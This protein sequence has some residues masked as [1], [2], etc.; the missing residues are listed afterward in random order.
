MKMMN[1]LAAIPG[2]CMAVSMP[3]TG[4]AAAETADFVFKNGAVYTIDS[5]QPRA[6]AIAV[7]GKTI[8]YVGGNAGADA[9]VG[10]DTQ[11]I[12][13][14]GKMLLPGFIDAHA[15]PTHAYGTVGVDVQ[16][17]DAAAAVAAVK[18]WAD[19]HPDA[20]VIL[21]YGWRFNAFPLTGPTKELLDK[22][23][24]DR[25][26]VLLSID[27]HNT[28]LNSKA[29]AMAGID[30]STKD[31][32]PPTSYYQRDEKGEPTGY[33][34][35]VPAMQAALAKLNPPSTEVVS[36]A[37]R[38]HVARLA[39]V[40]VTGVYDAGMVPFS[41]QD[42]GY[43][44]Y[45]G[46]EKEDALPVRVVGSFYWNDPTVKDPVGEIQKLHKKFH[47]ELVQAGALK[48][49]VDGGDLA[50]TAVML[51]PYADRPGFHGDFVLEPK[52][53]A[54][55]V[56]KAQS[57]GIDTHAHVFGDGAMKAYLDA[58]EQAERAYPRSR[59]RHTAAHALYL[60]DDLIDRMARLNVT[61]AQS[62]VWHTPEPIN[63][64][65][66]EQTIGKQV[67]FTEYG[68]SGSILQKGGRLAL[69]SDWPSAGYVST[70]KPGTARLRRT[71]TYE[72]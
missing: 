48:I 46:L 1:R 16:Y 14:K 44:L 62:P 53:F 54:P 26:V 60:T 19:E 6:E 15:H 17:D 41:A 35:E 65:S 43:D 51:Q 69:G 39:Q 4:A 23:V 22:V 10:K 5:L 13:L 66:A 28:W 50:H 47:S 27:L 59:S 12:D 32:L 30:A 7:T 57:L 55:A 71:R 49:N 34:V 70:F 68:R 40:G 21:G 67:H 56:M 63:Q 31:P 37:L 8:S 72:T 33:L 64:I 61:A 45:Q 36:S 52:D 58:V 2:L 29:L 9:F 20:K 11:V 25:P 38:A 3:L 24:P 42:V 18:R